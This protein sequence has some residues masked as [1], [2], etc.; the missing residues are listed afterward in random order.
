[1]FTSST[2]L[3]LNLLKY[4]FAVVQACVRR[5]ATQV[6]FKKLHLRWLASGLDISVFHRTEAATTLQPLI[7][8]FIAQQLLKRRV[9]AVHFSALL[10]WMQQQ[11]C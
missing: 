9:R 10:S 1:M 6:D 2:V 3:V 5:R 11:F 8:T 7:R 4:V